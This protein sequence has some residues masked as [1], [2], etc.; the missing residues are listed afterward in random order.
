MFSYLRTELRKLQKRLRPRRHKSKH[1]VLD[2]DEGFDYVKLASHCRTVNEYNQLHIGL[3]NVCTPRELAEI[4]KLATSRWGFKATRS[5]LKNY[6]IWTPELF[7]TPQGYGRRTISRHVILYQSPERESCDKD[8]LVAFTGNARRLM[9]PVC[10][11]LQYL[12]SRLWDVVVLKK[13]ARNSYQLGLEGISADFPGL[14][15]FIQTTF[16]STQY[17]RV[18][19]LGTSSGGFA[20]ILAARLMGAQ[21]GIS[22][23]GFAPKIA[24]SSAI[25]KQRASD[26]TDLRFVYASESAVDHQSALA[27]LGFFGGRLWPVPGAGHNPIGPMMKN[28]RFGEFID[29]MLA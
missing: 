27:L 22:I 8:L 20:A 3:E 1:V 24:Q 17:R 13:C 7:D 21:R 11:F 5:W 15:E 29:E 16:S 25:W 19:T 12:D 2:L 4:A 23:G 9:L 18:I 6:Q 26:R 10:V 28:G 14:V